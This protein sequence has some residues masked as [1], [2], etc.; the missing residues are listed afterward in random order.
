MRKDLRKW[1]HENYH[2]FVLGN[3]IED[4]PPISCREN[5]NKLN[6][7][8][9]FN[10]EGKFEKHPNDSTVILDRLDTSVGNDIYNPVKGIFLPLLFTTYVHQNT[11]HFCL[12]I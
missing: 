9:H 5:V 11:Y 12:H 8:P 3:G 1:C 10:F 6:Y 7:D 4:E 2:L